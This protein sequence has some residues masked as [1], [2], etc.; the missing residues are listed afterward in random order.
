MR[1]E[2]FNFVWWRNTKQ[3]RATW[4]NQTDSTKSAYSS[5]TSSCPCSV[6]PHGNISLREA[7]LGV[8]S[9]HFDSLCPWVTVNGKVCASDATAT[10]T[11]CMYSHHSMFLTFGERTRFLSHIVCCVPSAESALNVDKRLGGS[12]IRGFRE[13]R[14]SYLCIKTEYT[15]ARRVK[16]NRRF[17]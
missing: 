3:L 7:S 9:S 11:T 8:R 17:S 10:R 13:G 1:K 4:E 12:W 6:T 15:C 16:I 2:G 5:T 14:S